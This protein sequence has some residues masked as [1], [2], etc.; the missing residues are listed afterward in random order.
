M[1]NIDNS[2]GCHAVPIIN[3]NDSAGYI[4][5]FII[6][7][8]GA[9]GYIGVLADKG[10]CTQIHHAYPAG[11][12]HRPAGSIL[13]P[14]NQLLNQRDQLLRQHGKQVHQR[15]QPGKQAVDH[16]VSTSKLYDSACCIAVFIIYVNGVSNYI[17]VF[18][19]NGH[20]L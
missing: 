3:V 2:G 20:Y 9:S 7:V 4:A 8:N 11:N 15:N 12:D 13:H 5:G 19:S 10:Y 14:Q 1:I 17:D 16:A 6:N 18:K